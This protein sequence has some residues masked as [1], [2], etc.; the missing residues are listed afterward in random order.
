MTQITIIAQAARPTGILNFIDPFGKSSIREP[1]SLMMIHFTTIPSQIESM[2]I[3]VNNPAIKLK[4][5]E[6]ILFYN[7]IIHLY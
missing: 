5:S 3:M 6:T 2:R 4:K 7:E 1:N